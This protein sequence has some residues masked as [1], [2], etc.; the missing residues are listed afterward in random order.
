MGGRPRRRWRLHGASNPRAQG[1]L[2]RRQPGAAPGG[3]G[4]RLHFAEAFR[5]C[6]PSLMKPTDD[7]LGPFSRAIH[8]SIGSAGTAWELAAVGVVEALHVALSVADRRN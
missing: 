8:A 4:G 2:P 6:P 3:R 1:A 5:A 7:K